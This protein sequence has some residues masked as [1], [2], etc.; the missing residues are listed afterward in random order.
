MVQTQ[1]YSNVLNLAFMLPIKEQRQL[2]R[3]VQTNLDHGQETERRRYSWEELRAEVREA[4][5]Q[6]AQGACYTSE[7][8]DQL[9]DEFITKELNVVL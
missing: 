9:F 1:S 3:D 5:E 4:E 8:D 7:E 2:I 6:I